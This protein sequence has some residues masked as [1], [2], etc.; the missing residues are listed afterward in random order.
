[1]SGVKSKSP[2]ACIGVWCIGVWCGEAACA[3]PAPLPADRD[4]V[5]NV[6]DTF[7]YDDNIFRLPP[8][9]TAGVTYPGPGSSIGDKINTASLGMT[10]NWTL[11]LQS[12]IAKLNLADNL[13][14][15]NT[16]LD[17]VSAGAKLE[18]D[19]VLGNLLTGKAGGDYTR[20]LADFANTEFYSKDII[21]DADYYAGG[22]WDLGPHWRLNTNVRGETASHSATVREGD[23]Y[24][25]AAGSIGTEYALSPTNSLGLDY[26]FTHV[27]F[28]Q[29]QSI[30]GTLANRDY[31]DNAI[32]VY[33]KYS[34]TAV[35]TL[36][37]GGGYVNRSYN[38]ASLGTS[39]SGNFSGDVWH[40]TLNWQPTLQT[41]IRVKEWRDLRA[42]VDA[43]SNYFVSR[44]MSIGPVWSPLERLVVTL[45]LARENQN[46]I[47]D[48]L[49][50]GSLPQR[51]D[52][53]TTGKLKVEYKIRRRVQIDVGYNYEKR[54]SDEQ[55]VAYDDNLASIS[56]RYSF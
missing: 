54:T 8:P 3:D 27:G 28:R 31:H 25:S 12:V 39:A 22:I 50:I 4:I 10:G 2:G 53:L 34:L 43:E 46:Y 38:S 23:D 9:N 20:Y 48:D 13:F 16:D 41:G 24:E 51:R 55:T 21:S 49:V 32:S 47:G 19:W 29:G 35:T 45:E 40:V 26:Q 44:G 52:V 15:K 18:W 56:A 42:Y 17:N 6:A 1:M 37:A 14:L 5:F 7:T 11:G 36:E 30:D 33:V